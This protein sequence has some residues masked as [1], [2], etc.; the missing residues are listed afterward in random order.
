MNK[1]ASYTEGFLG[2]DTSNYR[3]SCCLLDETGQIIYQRR[4]L[5]IVPQGKLGLR[6]QEAVF[7]HLKALPPMFEELGEL[8]NVRFG[9][10]TRPRPVKGSYMPCFVV[11]ESFV[12]AF[13]AK[14]G[15]LS[16]SHQEN[17]IWAGLYENQNLIDK[18]FISLHLSGGTTE[19]LLVTWQNSELVVREVGRTSDISA[20]QFLDRTGLLLGLPFPAGPYLEKLAKKTDLRIGVTVKETTISYS[21]PEA[22]VKAL[23]KEGTKDEE[24]A[25]AALLAV[26]KSVSRVLRRLIEEHD[27]EDVLLVG[28]VMANELIKNRLKTDLEKKAKLHFASIEASGDNALGVA[29]A[30]FLR[31]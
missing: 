24:I 15:Y 17:H 11:G 1:L 10:T 14:R 8:K 22:K 28:G 26:A 25:Y 27:V 23:V 5:L 29:F 30:T 6:Q 16:L 13:A 4:P 12:R 7:Q 31:G 9:V 2:I 21:G 20:G 18:P 19:F 3:T